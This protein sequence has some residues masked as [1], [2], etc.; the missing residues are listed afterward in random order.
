MNDIIEAH[1]HCIRNKEELERS[2]YCGCFYCLSIFKLVEHDLEWIDNSLY[3][4]KNGTL[5]CPICHID[6]VIGDASG[7][8][9]TPTFL[10][11]MGK[12]WFSPAK[13]KKNGS[14]DSGSD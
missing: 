14:T 13:R 12:H 8:P 6:S 2:T 7:Y 1:K 11:E 3:G 4:T 9:I 5:L 10:A